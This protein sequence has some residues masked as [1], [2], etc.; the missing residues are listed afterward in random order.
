VKKEDKEDYIKALEATRQHDD[1]SIFRRFMTEMMVKQL[2]SDIAEFKQS[3]GDD[4][5][6]EDTVD[7]RKKKVST[8]ERI[9]ER[10]H[11]DNTLTAGT[12]ATE[13]GLSLAAINQQIATL[14]R[15]GKLV[16]IGPP[17]GGYWE[18]L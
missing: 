7:K 8:K 10:L 11:M 9:L 18:I 14:K 2:E 6:V 5:S 16:R 13:F 12:L 1:L 3:V 17:K 4:E 15:E